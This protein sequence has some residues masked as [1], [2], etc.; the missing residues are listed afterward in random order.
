MAACCDSSPVQAVKLWHLRQ[1][2]HVLQG[3]VQET[4]R[5]V[6]FA[7]AL[8]CVTFAAALRC[9]TFAAALRCVTFAAALRCAT[10]AAALRD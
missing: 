7:A 10:F 2:L 1:A 3:L 9:V 8:R 4:L 6:T 5:C